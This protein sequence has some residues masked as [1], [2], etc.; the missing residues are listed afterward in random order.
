MKSVDSEQ[1]SFSKHPWARAG[2]MKTI[3]VITSEAKP[4]RNETAFR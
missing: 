1:F 4:T 3:A 2:L